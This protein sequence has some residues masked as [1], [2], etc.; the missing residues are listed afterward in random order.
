M[1][2]ISWFSLLVWRTRADFLEDTGTQRMTVMGQGARALVFIGV[3]P[4]PGEPPVQSPPPGKV[5]RTM[6]VR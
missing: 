1:Q 5:L 4:S 3:N 2:I 6:R